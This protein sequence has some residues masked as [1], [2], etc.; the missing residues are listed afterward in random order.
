MTE[1]PMLLG[2]V[3]VEPIEERLYRCLLAASP[4]SLTDLAG[5]IGMPVALLRGP[6]E[7]LTSLGFITALGDGAGLYV[8][9]PPDLALPIHVSREELKLRQRIDEIAAAR[10]GSQSRPRPH[11]RKP[12][13][14]RDKPAH[15]RRCRRAATDD[16]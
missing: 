8:P 4:Q 16:A 9:V 6:V 3:G 7:R 11:R 1:P 5:A 15:D 13:A 12:P 14:G 2:Q 10:G